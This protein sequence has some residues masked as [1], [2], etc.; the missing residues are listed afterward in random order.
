[1]EA[2]ATLTTREISRVLAIAKRVI[3]DQINSLLQCKGYAKD[4]ATGEMRSFCALGV[5]GQGID[6]HNNDQV[7]LKVWKMIPK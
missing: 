2:D 6:Y 5:G 4:R 1:M 3:E 7:P